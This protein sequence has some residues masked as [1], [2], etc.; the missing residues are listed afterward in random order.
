MVAAAESWLDDAV[1]GN[2]DMAKLRPDFRAHMIPSHRAALQ[3][4]STLGKRSYTLITTDRRPPTTAYLFMVKT[5]KKTLIYAYS[6]DDDGLVAGA[7]V[8]DT[9]KY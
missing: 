7:E 2:V 3:A 5:A 1:A 8:I 4:L 9:V 6:R